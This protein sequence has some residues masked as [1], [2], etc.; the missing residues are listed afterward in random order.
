MK[1]ILK[2]FVALLV[3]AAV[4]GGAYAWF[5]GRGAGDDALTKV[6]VA[7]GP[8]PHLLPNLAPMVVAHSFFPLA[9][10][11]AMICSESPSN[12]MV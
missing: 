5:K 4:G 2:I 10:S 3:V 8:S 11:S 7:R 12:P 1:R 6:G 9:A